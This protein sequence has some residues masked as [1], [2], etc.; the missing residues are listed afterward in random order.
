MRDGILI[1]EGKGNEDW[2][3]SSAHGSGRIIA[4]NEV[5]HKI[6]MKEFK[7][8]MTG[9]YST[10]IVPEVLDECP[11]A[12]KDTEVIKAALQNTITIIEQLK[13]IINVKA[14]N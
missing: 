9:V 8:S 7:E 11:M 3:Y 1:A 14:L 5:A 2:N 12:Y 6:S 4:R 10:S 13:P